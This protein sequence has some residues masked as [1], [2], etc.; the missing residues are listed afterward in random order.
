MKLLIV[1]DEIQLVEALSAIFKQHKYFVDVAYN[2]EDGLNFALTDNYDVIILDLML[3]KINGYSILKTLRSYKISTPIL[4]LSAKSQVEDKIEGLD[5]GADDYFTKPFDSRELIARIKALTRRKSDF[6]GDIMECKNVKLNR[7]THELICGE[8][9]IFL[10]NKEYQI[11]E[12]LLN[13]IG[14]I[15]PKE[16][17][18]EKIW[19]YD[20]EAEYNAIEVYVSFLRKKLLALNA[21]MQIKMI[22][23]SGYTIGKDDD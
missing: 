1:D 11:M 21:D 5:L 8:E 3:P 4:M 6:S 17:F 14:N 9:K 16:R 20:T 7:N 22:R 12:M 10:G 2:G 13:N 19:G 15:I 23:G 18:I